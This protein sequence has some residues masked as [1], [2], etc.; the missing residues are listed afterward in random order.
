[1][2]VVCAPD[3]FKESM[4]AAHAAA[5]MAAGV[6]AA[7]PDTIVVEVPLSDG[8]EGFVAALAAGLGADLRH[9]TVP[10]AL[11]RPTRAAWALAGDLA[12]IEVAQAVGLESIAPAERDVRQ[13]TTVG[14]GELIGAALDAGARRLVIGLGGSATNDGGAGLLHALGVRFRAADGTKLAP[15]PAAL[16]HLTS[17]DTTGLDPRLAEVTLEAACDVTHPLCGPDGASA[18]FGPQKG[19]DAGDVAFL[20]GVLAR[21]SA[22]LAPAEA[23][24]PGAGAAG[25]LGWALLA[26]GATVRPGFDVVADAV[27]LDAALTDADLVLTGEGSVD[28][29]TLAGKAPAGV[30]RLAAAHGVPVVLFGGRLAP[31]AAALLGAGVHRLVCITPEGTALATALA[32]GPEHLAAAAAEVMSG[33]AGD[34]AQS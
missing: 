7:R 14:V 12:V 20:D 30:A 9:L 27:G 8:G 13:A 18:V 31:D 19:A 33:I 32:R 29:Q 23:H 34:A 4:T 3:S 11:G 15:T 1:M 25:G 2:K 28:A 22:A 17:V 5:A 16:A 24:R 10:D 21:V 26:L 6:R